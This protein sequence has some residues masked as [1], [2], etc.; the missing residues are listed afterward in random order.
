M[1]K[2]VKKDGGETRRLLFSI[3]PVFTGALQVVVQFQRS[4]M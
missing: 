2:P 3:F 1:Q 4:R